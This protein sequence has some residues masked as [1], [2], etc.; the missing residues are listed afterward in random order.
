VKPGINERIRLFQRFLTGFQL[1]Q[2]NN[3]K[4]KGRNMFGKQ[5]GFSLV[6][7]M[8]VVAI[9]AIIAVVALPKYNRYKAQAARNS[10]QYTLSEMA[11]SYKAFW[12]ANDLAP[13]TLVDIM[14]VPAGTTSLSIGPYIVDATTLTAV[15][16]QAAS[17]CVN[18]IADNLT[19]NLSN[20][21]QGTLD[22]P[23]KDGL[24]ECKK[25]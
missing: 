23:A 4:N 6:E 13:T 15:T 22:D 3:G 16:A 18:G 11:R 12:L 25:P 2:G 20:Q 24:E 19:I 7:L 17:L 10:V 8:V 1:C 21:S 14:D 9:L 5:S